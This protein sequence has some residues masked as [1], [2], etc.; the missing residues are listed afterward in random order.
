MSRFTFTIDWLAFTVS[1]SSPQEM[2]HILEAEWSTGETG[3]LGY[4][5]FWILMESQRGLGK[6]GTGCLVDLGKS[7]SISRLVLL[8]AGHQ[9]KSTE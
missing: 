6:L 1:E 7:I 5:M 2:A 8:Q 3:F 4:P 9:R